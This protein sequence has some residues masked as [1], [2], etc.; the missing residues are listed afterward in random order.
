MTAR[1]IIERSLRVSVRFPA[2]PWKSQ[3]R[4][5][6]WGYSFRTD[7]AG[8]SNRW[9]SP[10]S[11]LVSFSDMPLD[12]SSEILSATPINFTVG[13]P[14]PSR[15]IEGNYLK[16]W[17]ALTTKKLCSR[18]MYFINPINR[19]LNFLLHLTFLG[20][21]SWIK[22]TFLIR[23]NSSGEIRPMR[24]A[25]SHVKNMRWHSLENSS[26]KLKEPSWRSFRGKYEDK[27]NILGRIQ[28]FFRCTVQSWRRCLSLIWLII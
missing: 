11:V 8:L 5:N 24:Y 7:T 14:G 15:I 2:R 18:N 10:A 28:F 17:Y 1:E 9:T 27:W 3:A 23:D 12:V 25:F 21:F 16:T 19:F 26:L 22:N 20:T 13:H 6:L 4:R